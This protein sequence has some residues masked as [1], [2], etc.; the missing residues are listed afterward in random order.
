MSSPGCRKAPPIRYDLTAK[1]LEA[2]AMQAT[3]WS[4]TARNRRD[5]VD[6]ERPLHARLGH[7]GAGLPRYEPVDPDG[8]YRDG[9]GTRC[10]RPSKP[11]N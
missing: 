6:V 11:G 4:T 5:A 7:G 8:G 3:N 10:N 2:R 1:P 9:F